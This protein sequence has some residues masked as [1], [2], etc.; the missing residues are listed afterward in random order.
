VWTGCSCCYVSWNCSC[1]SYSG[2]SLVIWDLAASASYKLRVGRSR[3]QA[4]LIIRTSSCCQSA[5]ETSSIKIV[6]RIC[7]IGKCKFLVDSQILNWTN[8]A[9]SMEE[10][11]LG[12]L[13]SKKLPTLEISFTKLVAFQ[14]LKFADTSV[15]HSVSHNLFIAKIYTSFT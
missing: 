13:G 6:Q 3:I 1:F 5:F 2:M 14:L 15:R 10:I 12:N 7:I 4:K 8:K 9:C 11:P